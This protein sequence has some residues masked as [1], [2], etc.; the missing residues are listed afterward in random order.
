MYTPLRQ[1]ASLLVGVGA[2]VFMSELRDASRDEWA[3]LRDAS[4]DELEG[5]SVR[6]LISRGESENT[7]GRNHL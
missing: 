4:R 3:E 5:V 1:V 6:R 7:T 2:T